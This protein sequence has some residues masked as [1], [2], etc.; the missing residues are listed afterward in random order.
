MASY[1][2]I[3]VDQVKS[4]NLLFHR[5]RMMNVVLSE[6]ASS[7]LRGNAAIALIKLLIM[8]YKL[9]SE[10]FKDVR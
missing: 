2:G 3:D 1:S 6:L 4:R 5:L 9:L 8:L 7:R 10:I